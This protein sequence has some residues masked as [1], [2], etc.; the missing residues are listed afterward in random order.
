MKR[1]FT[2]IGGG[3]A[4]LTTAIA[5][6]NI[7]IE[8]TVMEADPE[9]RST[10]AGIVLAANAV[11]A[12]MYLG[13]YDRLSAAGSVIDQ[14]TIYDDEGKVISRIETEGLKHSLADFAIHRAA[15]HT[16][17]LDQLDRGSVL[18][19]KRCTGFTKTLT[20]YKLEFA[21]GSKDESTYLIVADG[22]YSTIRQQVLPRAKLRYAGYTCWRGITENTSINMK[23]T[24]ETWGARGRFGSVQ[25]PDHRIY[26]FA[27]K[28]AGANDKNMI[29]YS[30]EDLAD[31]FDHYHSPIGQIIL[32]THREKIIW[33]D[34]YDLEP[35][36]QYAFEDLVLIGDAAHA[37]TPNMGQGACQAIEDAVVLANCIKNNSTVKDAFQ[38]FEQKRLTRTHEIVKQSWR[39]GKVAQLENGL[40]IRLRNF[41]LQKLPQQF[42]ERQ[43]SRIYDVDFN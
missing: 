4:G 3:I 19:G 18:T 12:Y 33:N 11:K 13:L 14:F 6:R 32:S 37:T 38:S 17:L 15:L 10:G 34:I 5:L 27:C 7:G 23:E 21:D 35:I 25:L 41:I 9:F 22:I 8:A 26:W 40:L 2:I 20:G 43:L 30:I 28:N 16:V 42:Y 39:L 36:R 24:S 1:Q 29:Q 31:N